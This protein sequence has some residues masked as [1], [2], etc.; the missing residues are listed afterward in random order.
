MEQAT[1]HLGHQTKEIMEVFH[2]QV[3]LLVRLLLVVAAVLVVLAV[4][5]L[6]GLAQA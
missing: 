1:A 2:S 5:E 6:L 3:I 4:Q